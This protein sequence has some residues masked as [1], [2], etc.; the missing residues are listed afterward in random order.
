MNTLKAEAIIDRFT[1]D[2]A[3]KE[4]IL[5]YV[6]DV[7]SG[8]TSLDKII[9]AN[10]KDPVLKGK[11]KE[12]VGK[13]NAGHSIHAITSYHTPDA[14]RAA[15][16]AEAVSRHIG[17]VDHIVRADPITQKIPKKGAKKGKR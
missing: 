17:A 2:P 11:I 8:K 15:S 3:A 6:Q 5:K 16:A 14:N 4:R 7:K 12:I 1:S 9:N 13:V 10:T